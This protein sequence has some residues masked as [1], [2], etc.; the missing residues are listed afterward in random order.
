MDKYLNNQ[1]RTSAGVTVTK[2]YAEKSSHE[3]FVDYSKV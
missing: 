1:D 3:E 2:E